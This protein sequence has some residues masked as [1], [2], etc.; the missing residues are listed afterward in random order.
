[1]RPDEKNLAEQLDVAF[2]KPAVTLPKDLRTRF[3]E[4]LRR[5]ARRRDCVPIRLNG[6]RIEVRRGTTV[7]G[8][9]LRSG[10]RLMHACGARGLCSTCR[11]QVET[12]E[13]HLSAPTSREKL[14][15]RAHLAFDRRTRLGC[16]ARIKGPVEIRSVFPLC[17]NL[18]GD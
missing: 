13:E 18:P 5:V 1:M 14:S 11:V 4:G 17:G 10:F 3:A 12:G 15:L 9:A 6:E 7:L 2:G 16:Q 8:A